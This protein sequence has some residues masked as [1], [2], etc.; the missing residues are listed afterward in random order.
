MYDK[1]VI[2]GSF[3]AVVKMPKGTAW[4]KLLSRGPKLLCEG[5]SS[6]YKPYNSGY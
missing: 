5:S 4:S 3:Y 2:I 1:N 6:L